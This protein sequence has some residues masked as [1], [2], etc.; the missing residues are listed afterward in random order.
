MYVARPLNN[1]SN[2]PSLACP[3]RDELAGF[4]R[5]MLL[6]H[7][8][9]EKDGDYC[10]FTPK[11]PNNLPYPSPIY[12]L[13]VSWNNITKKT[14]VMSHILTFSKTPVRGIRICGAFYYI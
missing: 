9:E 4:G 5:Q 3:S 1:S 14:A 12:L 6:S 10:V 8:E 11:H 2:D 7:G 13:V